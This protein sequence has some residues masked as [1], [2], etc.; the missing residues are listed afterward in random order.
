[1]VKSQNQSPFFICFF[2]LNDDFLKSTFEKN[3]SLF[4]HKL[5]RLIFSFNLNQIVLN[6]AFSK[7]KGSREP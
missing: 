1:M 3:F 2:T 6:I 5:G 7:V 4:S